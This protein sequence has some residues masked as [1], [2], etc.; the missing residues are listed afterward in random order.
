MSDVLLG[1]MM[2]MLGFVQG[3]E[4]KL[5]DAM[6]HS[7][8]HTDSALSIARMHDYRYGTEIEKVVREASE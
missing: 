2:Y 3:L 6:N 4:E 7:D 1:D 8:I 5:L